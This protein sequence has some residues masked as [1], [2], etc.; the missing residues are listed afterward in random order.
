M[1]LNKSREGRKDERAKGRKD[2]SSNP[3]SSLQGTKQSRTMKTERTY[4]D[5]GCRSLCADVLDWLRRA[6]L[7]SGCHAT[8]AMTKERLTTTSSVVRDC[9]AP[10]AM[11]AEGNN[12]RSSLRG[13][14]QSRT[15]KTERTYS[16]KGCRSLCAGIPDWLRRAP[17]RSGC[18]ASLAMTAEGK[19]IPLS[20]VRPFALSPFRPFVL[21]PFFPFLPLITK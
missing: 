18:H 2:E 19:A 20:P 12:R 5:K 7:R 3:S 16:D 11:T 10:L 9:H 15:M 17:L 4:S 6:P 8:L 14:K 13:T 21:S 1:T